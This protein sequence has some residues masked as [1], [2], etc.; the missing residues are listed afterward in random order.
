[1]FYLER[2]D[3]QLKSRRESEL[4]SEGFFGRGSEVFFKVECSFLVT[5]VG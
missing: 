3:D 5:F 1:M 2:Q 4:R